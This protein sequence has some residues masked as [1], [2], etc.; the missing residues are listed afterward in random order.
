MDENNGIALRQVLQLIR[1][2]EDCFLS[3]QATNTLLKDEF[4]HVLIA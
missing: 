4:A 3:E 1:H 2:K